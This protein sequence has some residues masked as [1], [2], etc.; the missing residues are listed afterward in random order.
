[1]HVAGFTLGDWFDYNAGFEDFAAVKLDED[2][3]PQWGW[4]VR[5]TSD[6]PQALRGI[7]EETSTTHPLLPSS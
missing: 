2:G 5:M 1:M 3:E 7:E 4:Q 6:M